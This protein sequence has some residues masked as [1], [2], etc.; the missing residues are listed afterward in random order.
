MKRLGL[1]PLLCVSICSMDANCDPVRW[2]LSD[3]GTGHVYN[4]VHDTSIPSSWDQAQF[5]LQSIGGYLAT[6]TSGAEQQFIEDML[7][8]QEAPTGSYWIGLI[9]SDKEGAYEWITG[10]PLSYTNWGPGE[11]NNAPAHRPENRGAIQ[12]TSD[13]DSSMSTFGRRG[14]WNDAPEQGIN[15]SLFL[16]VNAGG[17]IT[18]FVPLPSASAL[19]ASGLLTLLLSRCRQRRSA[20]PT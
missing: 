15:T 14:G 9:E 2:R 10:E 8:D 5:T 13:A 12:W 20:T 16:D 1:L 17:Y 18:E 7:I 3:G 6:I 11:P 4:F 19:S